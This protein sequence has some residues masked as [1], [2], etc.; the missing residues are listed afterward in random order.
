M[1]YYFHT[2]P[3]GMSR[4]NYAVNT[5]LNPNYEKMTAEQAAFWDANPDATMW[6]VRQCRLAPKTDALEAAKARKLAEIDAYD[7]SENVNGFIIG[8][9][10]V[11]L[12]RDTRVALRATLEVAQRKGM[13]QY[14]MWFGGECYTMDI[15][16]ELAL[17]DELELYAAHCYNVTALHRHNVSE[18]DNAADVENFDVTA[19]YRERLNFD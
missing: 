17:L 4:L 7:V 8:G 10:V 3:N 18:M 15:A 9:S 1:E 16:T 12:D 14:P 2:N 5:A 19:D 6:E 13:T 11:W